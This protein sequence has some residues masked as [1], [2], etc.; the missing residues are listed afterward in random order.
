[1]HYIQLVP[2]NTKYGDGLDI[3]IFYGIGVI[4]LNPIFQLQ[5]QRDAEISSFFEF[6]KTVRKHTVQ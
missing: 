4:V 3:L 2:P 1:M 5:S 6:E